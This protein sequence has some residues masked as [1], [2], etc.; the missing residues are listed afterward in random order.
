MALTADKV[1]SGPIVTNRT[2]LW[3]IHE[4]HYSSLSTRIHRIQP[5]GHGL[6]HGYFNHRCV[7]TRSTSFNDQLLN[8]NGKPVSLNYKKSSISCKST[9]AN[10]TEEKDCVTT[11]DDVSDLTR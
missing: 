4:K 10:N 2:I 9:G 3:R 5:P 11:Y 1:S 7:L 6:E 8:I